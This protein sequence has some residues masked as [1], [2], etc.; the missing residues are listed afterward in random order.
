MVPSVPVQ[1]SVPLAGV[2]GA[3]RPWCRTRLL[4]LPEARRALAALVRFLL[5]PLVR[6]LGGPAWLWGIPSAFS[7]VT[8]GWEPGKA[9]AVREWEAPLPGFHMVLMMSPMWVK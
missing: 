6:L 5:A 7:H 4:A 9:A 2:A 3:A 1:R 8:G